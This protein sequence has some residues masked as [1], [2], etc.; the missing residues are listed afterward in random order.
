MFNIMCTHMFDRNMLFKVLS[1]I[2]RINVSGH[3]TGRG[4]L[5]GIYGEII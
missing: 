1:G 4:L 3:I 2:L 5:F